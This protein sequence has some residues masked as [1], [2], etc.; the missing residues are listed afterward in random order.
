ME[1]IG[2]YW[3]FL[4]IIGKYWE[5]QVLTT[6]TPFNPA[7]GAR[8]AAPRFSRNCHIFIMLCIF[9]SGPGLPPK[10]RPKPDSQ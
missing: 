3:E 4:G 8:A 9:I 2:Y 6:K 7:P 1:N 10:G 5:L